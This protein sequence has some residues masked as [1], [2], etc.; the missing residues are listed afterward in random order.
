MNLGVLSLFDSSITND[1]ILIKE[2]PG[3]GDEHPKPHL[4]DDNQPTIQHPFAVMEID[5]FDSTFIVMTS[6]DEKYINIFKKLYPLS[7]ENFDM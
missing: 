2:L 3:I 7:T 5:A 1:K 6:K 4:F